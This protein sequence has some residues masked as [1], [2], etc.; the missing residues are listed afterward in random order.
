[1]RQHFYTV[2][3]FILPVIDFFYPPF[4]KLMPIQTFRYLLCGAANTVLGLVVFYISYHYIF[5]TENFHFKVYAFESYTASLIL[6]FT[7]SF[8]FGFFLMKYVVFDDSRIKGHVQLFRY[9]L[10]CTFNLLLNYA[11]LKLAV[12]ILHIYPI[13]AQVGTTFIVTIVSYL[14]QRHF[15]FRKKVL[16]DYIDEEKEETILPH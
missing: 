1:M 15:S 5:K 12:E 13:F 10:V 9:L 14:A 3:D 4:K 11:L 2:R 6:A 8:L 7:A 16:P